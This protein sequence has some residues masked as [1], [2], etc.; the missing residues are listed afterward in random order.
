MRISKITVI[1]FL[2]TTTAS[3]A[4]Y[5]NNWAVGLKVG[6]PLGIN[7]RKYFAYGEKAFDLNVGSYGFL[8]G[9]TRTYRGEPLYNQA[10]ITVQ[11]LFQYHRSLGRNERFHYYYGYGAHLNNRKKILKASTGLRDNKENLFS[12]GP[13]VNAGIEYKI[14]QNDLGVFLD[15]GGYLELA[16]SLFFVAPMANIGLRLH[17]IK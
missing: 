12:F 17:L 8:F 1:L 10:G 15:A 14:P 4:Q 16:P 3:I 6:E 11:G 2:I 9:S 13:A 7:I 5:D